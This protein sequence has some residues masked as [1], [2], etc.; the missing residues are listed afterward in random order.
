MKKI[1]LKDKI[2]IMF[3][4][5]IVGIFVEN[6][7][8]SKK[9]IDKP[10]SKSTLIL[11]I[12]SA[13]D[14]STLITGK[15]YKI[16]GSGINV[17]QGAG[18]NFGKVVNQKATS[19][20]KTT[21]YI[22]VDNTLTIFEE[23]TKNGWSWIRV[24][25]PER[26]SLS[27][28]GW[29]S[30]KFLRGKKIDSSGIEIFTEADFSFDNKTRPYKKIIIAGVNKIHREN[31]RCK[32][33]DTSSAYISSSKGSKANPVFFV[34]CGKDKVFNVFFSKSDI[35]KDKKFIAKKHI[36]KSRAIDLCENYAKENAIHPSTVSFSRIINLSVHE[37]PNGRT[38]VTSTF[39]AKN[40]FDLELKYKISCLLS[41][42]G[43]IEANMN[44][45]K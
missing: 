36:N 11:S 28:R 27:H 21:H 14:T 22:S 8:G 13:C 15:Q 4:M 29:V 41:S 33:I 37:T 32:N 42:G 30:S 2:I 35:K 34:T 26:L 24:I 10:S 18:I 12:P 6:N 20:M 39:T 40:S 45:E 17:R 43:L 23:C 7:I 38:R 44:E 19:I 31:S 9:I 5:V 1:D 16:L 25:K 3:V